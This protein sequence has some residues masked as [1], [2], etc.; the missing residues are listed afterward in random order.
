MLRP[1]WFTEIL[2]W[3]GLL[4]SKEVNNLKNWAGENIYLN[5]PRNFIPLKISTTNF[6]NINANN[7]SD[8]NNKSNNI[9]DC[10]ITIN[11]C[12]IYYD[13]DDE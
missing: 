3:I 10:N 12:Y 8:S 2:F 5:I 1:S 13:D 7:I 4:L 6:Y 11:Y 9:S